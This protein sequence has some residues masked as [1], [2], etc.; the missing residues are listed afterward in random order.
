[1]RS[2]LLTVMFAAAALAG[3]SSDDPDVRPPPRTVA[4]SPTEGVDSA[5]LGALLVEHWDVE[6]ALDPLSAT[7]LGDH[8]LDAQLPPVRRDDVLALRARRRAL[9]AQVVA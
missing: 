1:M 5:A 4:P 6:A 8:R 9:L 2:P 3:C 7:Y